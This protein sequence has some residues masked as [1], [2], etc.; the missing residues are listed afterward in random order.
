M[1]TVAAEIRA[2]AE[3]TTRVEGGMPIEEMAQRWLDGESPQV[4][5]KK[6]GIRREEVTRRIKRWMLAG[7][8]DAAYADLVTDALV[9]R[10]ADADD[11]LEQA[12]DPVQIAK[13][14]EMA[15][16]ARMDFERRRPALY[17][18]KQ[19]V[20]HTG[21]P[22]TFTVV[23]LD[24]PSGGGGRVIDGSPVALP[25]PAEGSTEEG[26]LDGLRQQGQAAGLS[27]AGA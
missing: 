2:E 15:R 24:A 17:G 12:R 4:L 27:G 26:G 9:N 7:R 18:Q 11:R 6:C 13:Y 14:R 23:L 16:F 22:P 1:G 20:R 5:G 19:E 8:G 25:A 21:G 10:I 3:A